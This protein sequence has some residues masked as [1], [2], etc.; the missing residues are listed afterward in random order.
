[1]ALYALGE[2]APE[3]DPTA[4]VFESATVIGQ[5]KLA[6]GSSVWAHASLRGDN[7]PITIGRG[8][9]VQEGAVLHTDKGAPLTVGENVTI[10]HQAMLHGC[11]VGDGA[12]IGIQAVV[13]N[14]AR[15]GCNCL[16]GAGALVTEGKEFP[17]NSLI[18]GSPAKVVRTLSDEEIARMHANTADYV[19]RAAEYR[20][21]LRRIHA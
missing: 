14:H 7:E 10:G 13:L 20:Q 3:L 15:I 4:F 17:D 9:N 1:M 12:L 19:I 18:L 8:S 6:A 21:I 11:T 5:V 16:V 2:K